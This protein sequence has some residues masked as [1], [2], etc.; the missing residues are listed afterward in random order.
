[1]SSSRS[2]AKEIGTA[3]AVLA[4]Y[5][6]TILTPLHHARASQLD[7]AAIGYQTLET[8][9]ALCSSATDRDE[10]KSLVVKC[11]ANGIGKKDLVEPAPVVIGLGSS[12]PVVSVHYADLPHRHIAPPLNLAASPRAPPA[13]V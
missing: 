8:G 11:P 12:A 1:V 13:L 2:I 10:G 5:L 6:L 3:F 9:W 7:F 4:L